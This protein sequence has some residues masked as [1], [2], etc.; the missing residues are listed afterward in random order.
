SPYLFSA[1]VRLVAQIGNPLYRRIA[2]CE[3]RDSFNAPGIFV[4]SQNAIL[5]YS[6]ARQSRNSIAPNVWSAA[7]PAAFGY[8]ARKPRTLQAH[9][10]RPKRRDTPHSKRFATS[11]PP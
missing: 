8:L 4:A 1:G 11:E 6:P 10:Q 5:R 9:S 3:P 7:Y 2:F